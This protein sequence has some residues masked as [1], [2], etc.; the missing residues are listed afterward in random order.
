MPGWEAEVLEGRRVKVYTGW[1]LTLS[2][3]EEVRAGIADEIGRYP[4]WQGME[5][6]KGKGVTRVVEER[7]RNG[8]GRLFAGQGREWGVSTEDG[9]WSSRRIS[10]SISEQGHSIHPP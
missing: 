10:I 1:V 7:W 9:E 3:Y 5:H 6:G 8:D 4:E 2:G